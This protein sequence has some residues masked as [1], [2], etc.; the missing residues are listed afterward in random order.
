[1]WKSGGDMCDPDKEVLKVCLF[2]L[3]EYRFFVLCYILCYIS[4]RKET[5]HKKHCFFPFRST[6]VTL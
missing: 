2:H 6:F 4:C 5:L 1:M 3:T